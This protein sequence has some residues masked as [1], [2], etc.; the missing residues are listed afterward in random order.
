MP[1]GIQH[2]ILSIIALTSTLDR[3]DHAYNILRNSD[4]IYIYIDHQP[5]WGSYVIYDIPDEEFLQNLICIFS[6][7]NSIWRIIIDALVTPLVVEFVIYYELHLLHPKEDLFDDVTI[8][9]LLSI[10]L[11]CWYFIL[12]ISII[13]DPPQWFIDHT[14]HTCYHFHPF[15][16]DDLLQILVQWENW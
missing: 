7:P 4:R 8:A 5:C 10:N 15:T 13:C 2:Q 11:W 9:H 16:H 14:I 6:R 12:S 3:Y 1:K